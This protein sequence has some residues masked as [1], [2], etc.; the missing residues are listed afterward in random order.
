MRLV[1]CVHQACRVNVYDKLAFAGLTQHVRTSTG[2]KEQK[3]IHGH[4][5]CARL[6][7]RVGAAAYYCIGHAVHTYLSSRLKIAQAW[8]LKCCS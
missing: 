6:W 8:G 1:D 2:F 7:D 5:H 3:F 4:M